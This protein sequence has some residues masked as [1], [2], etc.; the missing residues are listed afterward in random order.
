MT[1]EQLLF[2]ELQGKLARAMVLTVQC[3]NQNGEDRYLHEAD[4]FR[5]QLRKALDQANGLARVLGEHNL[6]DRPNAESV[7]SVA[8][9]ANQLVAELLSDG[10]ALK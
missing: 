9:T 7:I 5:Q 2:L 4:T 3:T 8:N 10:K 6:L 1:I